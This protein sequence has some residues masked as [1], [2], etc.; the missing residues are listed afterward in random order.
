MHRILGFLSYSNIFT[1]YY[2]IDDRHEN[3]TGGLFNVS[4]A[5]SMIGN[6]C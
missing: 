2:E 5:S 6:G 1:I 4:N 3:I